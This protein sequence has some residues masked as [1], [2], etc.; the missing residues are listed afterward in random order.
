MIITVVENPI[1]SA[2]DNSQINCD[3]TFDNG[4]TYPYTSN[5]A[6]MTEYGIVLWADLN[7]GRYGVI[8]PYSSTNQL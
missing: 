7:S 8:A 4:R 1:Y 3:V 6:D 5:A 2:E